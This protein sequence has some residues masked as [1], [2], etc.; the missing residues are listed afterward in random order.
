MFTSCNFSAVSSQNKIDMNLIWSSTI[1]VLECAWVACPC[2]RS[3]GK[4]SR[5]VNFRW[6]QLYSVWALFFPVFTIC[7]SPYAQLLEHAVIGHLIL[8]KLLR[9]GSIFFHSILL[10]Y[11]V[12]SYLASWY[13][14]FR[15][16]RPKVTILF[17]ECIC[18]RFLILRTKRRFLFR[19]VYK[20]CEA[21]IS[22]DPPLSRDALVAFFFPLTWP[23]N[24][25]VLR[26][27]SFL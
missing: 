1:F 14:S 16:L 7:C 8:W 3:H 19:I 22:F 21:K 15:L 23:T 17:L 10:P 2:G 24:E 27:L 25:Y 12:Y 18:S 5:S 9:V 26:D 20:L 6:A 4:N 11:D 13:A